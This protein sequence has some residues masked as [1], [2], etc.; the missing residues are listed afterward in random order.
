MNEHQV[1]IGETTF[2]GREELASTGLVDYGSLIWI[3]LQRSTTARE[4]IAVITGLSNE[5]G[6]ASE[7][8]SFSI[9][10]TDEVWI[11]EMVGKG[12][13]KGVVW[14]AMRIPDGAIS[15]HAN[16]ARI[17][18]LIFD[19][20]DNC[21]YADDVI[22]FAR[23]K[24]YFDGSDDDFSFS[25][26]YNPVTF[27]G[28]R[29]CDMRSYAFFSEVLG[30][31]QVSQYYDYV[32]G[33][34]QYDQYGY[35]TNRMPLYF[36]V[37]EE[38]KLST[39]QII[40]AMRNHFEGLTISLLD[41]PGAGPFESPY[42]WRPMDFTVDGNVYTNER[43][44]ATQQTAWSFVAQ[45]RS[46]KA[47]DLIGGIF[48]FG[49]D[50]TAHS[51]YVPF[52]CGHNQVHPSLA[53]GNGD[54]L[55]Y[56]PTS[57]F[58]LIQRIANHA[59]LRYNEVIV[60]INETLDKLEEEFYTSVQET[61]ELADGVYKQN[62]AASLATF[63][64]YRSNLLV[65]RAMKTLTKLE[66]FLLVK[67]IDGNT[68]VVENGEF[69]RTETGNCWNPLQSGYPQWYYDGIVAATGD[70]HLE[71]VAANN[72]EMG[73]RGCGVKQIDMRKRMKGI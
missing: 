71:T 70:L 1:A 12:D 64:T 22:T 24:G 56:S 45:A 30:D 67:Y 63:L 51:A 20:D 73:K 43:S 14:A 72:A 2:G 7:G 68:K 54:I 3:A 53:V 69:K 36:T 34:V 15:S 29:G 62:G 23:E 50:D 26:T 35:A 44:T 60:D 21:M 6:Y 27:S 65:D 28:A 9:M 32:L 61:D 52:Y 59:Y 41:V 33:N 38:K 48:W 19:D 4:A 39:L 10:D 18:Q 42:R 16:Q 49:V 46:G 40:K 11:L 8:E 66:N 5:Y 55:T 57:M 17:T 25:D 58:W 37:S 47:S 31:D 13:Q